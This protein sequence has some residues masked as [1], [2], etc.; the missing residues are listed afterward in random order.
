MREQGDEDARASYPGMMTLS[1]CPASWHLPGESLAGPKP[2]PQFH[3]I[4]FMSPFLCTSE[5]R[6][7]DPEMLVCFSRWSLRSTWMASIW[8]CRSTLLVLPSAQ[9]PAHGKRT[10]NIRLANEWVTRQGES[11]LNTTTTKTKRG[12]I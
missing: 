10:A 5:D 12:A 1:L 3:C 2:L 8:L 7:G 9:S 4:Y 11:K 6:E